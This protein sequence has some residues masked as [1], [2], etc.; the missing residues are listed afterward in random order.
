MLVTSKK[1]ALVLATLASVTKVNKIE[2]VALAKA[3]YIHY[4]FH[5]QKNN[6]N[7]IQ[8]LIDFGSKINVL[9][10]VYISKLGLRVCYTN[11]GA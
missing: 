7:K 5:F 11:V 3:P 8:A 2:E 4:L 9:T 6:K 1:L 10:P